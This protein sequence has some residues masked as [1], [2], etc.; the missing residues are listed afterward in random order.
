MSSFR[1]IPLSNNRLRLQKINSQVIRKAK[2]PA[3]Q[4]LSELDV[5]KEAIQTIN[6]LMPQIEKISKSGLEKTVKSALIADMLNNANLSMTE[7]ND[8]NNNNL[9]SLK[10]H[11]YS[12]PAKTKSWTP[13]KR[14][15]LS[16]IK[17]SVIPEQSTRFTREEHTLLKE[18]PELYNTRFEVVDKQGDAYPGSDINRVLSFIQKENSGKQ[19]RGPPG[20][21]AV[22]ERIGELAH[23]IDH[24][25]K[26]MKNPQ[27]VEKLDRAIKRFEEK[28]KVELERKHK[29]QKTDQVGSGWTSLGIR[30]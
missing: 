16:S 20:T 8:D 3:I 13:L 26:Y 10:P 7:P 19:K 21:R 30:Y 11:L 15:E 23:K 6:K 28:Q 27:A 12:T 18:I 29:R 24:I 9:A 4:V 17:K 1:K 22:L 25:S 14:P 2:K 5:D